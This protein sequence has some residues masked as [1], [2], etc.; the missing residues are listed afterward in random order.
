MLADR[1]RAMEPSGIRRIFEL[2][3][4]MEDPINL[5]IGQAH[6]A[7][8]EKLVEAACRALRAG[9]N[10]YTVTQGL[11]ALNERILARVAAR[12]GRRPQASIVTVGVSGGLLLTFLALLDPGDEILLPD[13]HFV[14]YR[15]LANICGAQVK[16]YNLYP[17]FHLD[18]AEIEALVSPRTKIVLVNSPSN[19][20][21]GVLT[22]EELAAVAAAAER[23]GAIVVSD[24]IYD[25]FVYDEPYVSPVGM[26][27]RV[28]QLG[29]FSKTYGIPGWR[30][31]YATGP[32]SII[33]AMKTLQQFTFV[34]APTPLQHAVLEAAFELDMS[35]HIAGYRQ[36]RDRVA[37]SLHP[38]YE[39]VPPGGSFYAFPRLPGAL[40]EG[41]FM[42][43]ALG[44]RLLVVPGSAFSR[45][46]THF[47]L[48]F[49]AGDAELARGIA[50]LNEIAAEAVGRSS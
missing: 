3:A 43:A 16:F 20:T 2:M 42:E 40:G 17:S 21:G 1:M 28:V 18:P 26:T 8:P 45:R 46:A 11:P 9:H 36:R 4:T 5:S 10:R 13:P 37:R 35:E 24:E 27:E 29:G 48:S 33:D 25:E 38:A 14:I 32:A 22:R 19:P 41:A 50:T 49:A 44:R 47:R 12:Y 30:L 34:C 23:V 6:Y 15:Q 39:L 7:P 31:G